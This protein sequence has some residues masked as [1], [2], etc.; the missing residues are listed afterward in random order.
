M[1]SVDPIT[2]SKKEKNE[3]NDDGVC[4][5]SMHIRNDYGSSIT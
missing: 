1:G 3:K 4:V 2:N 5:C